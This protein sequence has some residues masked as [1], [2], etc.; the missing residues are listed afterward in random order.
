[1]QAQIV[2]LSNESQFRKFSQFFNVDD[3]TV[4]CDNARFYPFLAK[5]QVAYQTIDEFTIENQWD[6]LNAW[7]C[8]KAAQWIRFCTKKSIFPDIDIPSAIF[9]Y[10]SKMLIQMLKNYIFAKHIIEKCSPRRAVI[11]T[12]LSKRIYPDFSGNSY[13]NYFLKE[14]SLQRDIPIDPVDISGLEREQE[15]LRNFTPWYQRLRNQLI[16]STKQFIQALYGI[17]VKPTPTDVLAFGSLNHLGST[18]LQLKSKGRKISIFD[19][20][21]HAAL[22]RFANKHRFLYLIP[23]CFEK[24][25]C[26][27]GENWQQLQMQRLLN[28]LDDSEAQSIF[29][30]DGFSFSSFIK[31]NIFKLMA[32]YIHSLAENF[33]LFS[34]I[35]DSCKPKA[36]LVNDDFSARGGFFGAVL[37]RRGIQ[38]YCI[39][40]AN[41]A[42]DFCVAKEDQI[43]SQSKT[44]VNSEFEKQMWEARGWKGSDL[45]VTG[46]PRY[47]RLIQ[48]KKTNKGRQ[49]S[50]SEI[51]KLLYCSTG[52][53]VHSPNQRGYLGCHIVSYHQTQ[54]PRIMATFKAIKDLPVE[55]IIKP[56]SDYAVPLW[57]TFIRD[58]DPTGRVSVTSHKEDIFKLY[59][60][61][62]AMLVPYWS[63]AIM[64]TALIDLPTIFID[65]GPPRNHQLDKFAEAGC[66]AVAKTET[67]LRQEIEKIVANSAVSN[68]AQSSAIEFYLG[69]KD[70]QNTKR[71][72]DYII[73][74]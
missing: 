30:Y 56:H 22:H 67:I 15:Y 2:V 13:L 72:I 51:V 37:K 50:P 6:T 24:K 65:I 42:V 70:D 57:K 27:N 32:P 11:F 55:L 8:S 5:K 12:G 68:K 73:S 64:E 46:T 43:F 71:V 9:M 58:S 23:S 17:A 28:S 33:N 25:K 38:N 52:L 53:W 45:I 3:F 60:E 29:S 35:V 18:L 47:D 4:Y 59:F 20:D 7:G 14:L 31:E 19:L 41:L 16:K 21:Y 48:M 54:Y 10:F 61:C 62:D 49:K 74:K 39:S 1:M 26:L 40:H 69:K 44:F 36:A 66:C 34:Q 63:T